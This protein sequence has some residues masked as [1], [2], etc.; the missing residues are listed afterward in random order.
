MA[1]RTNFT[2]EKFSESN[3]KALKGSTIASPIKLK[4]SIITKSQAID[5]VV[6]TIPPKKEAATFSG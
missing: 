5:R 4:R 2:D 3:R 1:K 6:C